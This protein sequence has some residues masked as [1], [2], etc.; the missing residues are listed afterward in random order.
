ME[1]KS[2]DESLP[3]N[4]KLNE[5]INNVKKVKEKLAYQE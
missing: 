3:F 5:A 1:L 2:K 4:E